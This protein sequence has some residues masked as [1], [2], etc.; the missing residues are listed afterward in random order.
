MIDCSSHGIL[1]QKQNKITR[2]CPHVFARIS[3]VK[4]VKIDLTNLSYLSVIVHTIN[5]CHTEERVL[6]KEKLTPCS[7]QS[8]AIIV[9]YAHESMGCIVIRV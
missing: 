1:C 8:K 9:I 4:E 2:R 7:L 3:A 6:E 5:H